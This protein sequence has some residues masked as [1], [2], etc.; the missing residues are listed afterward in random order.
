MSSCSKTADSYIFFGVSGAAI[1]ETQWASMV[2]KD[3]SLAAAQIASN[4]ARP[5]IANFQS[6]MAAPRELAC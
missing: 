4:L 2:A 1:S 5:L 3:A 6:E